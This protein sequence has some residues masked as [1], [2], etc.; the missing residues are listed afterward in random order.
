MNKT[1]RFSYFAMAFLLLAACIG[2][3]S[4]QNYLLRSDGQ[5]RVNGT[6][7]PTTTVVS[8]GD[9]IE[10]SKGSMAKIAAPGVS[11]LVGENSRVSV[12]N[13]SLVDLGSSA[14]AP[15]DSASANFGQLD[16]AATSNVCR[17]AK[18]CYCKTAKACP[19][20]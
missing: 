10:T 8:P 20:Y 2:A 15:V 17:T 6:M 7:V 12:K 9:L 16:G 13:G 3:Q 18:L 5:V 19:N 14:S 11:L 4:Q 1:V